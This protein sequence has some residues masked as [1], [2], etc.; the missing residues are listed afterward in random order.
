GGRARCGARALLSLM[1]SDRCV[2]GIGKWKGPF[3]RSRK[4]P[5]GLSRVSLLPL[6]S[7]GAL[8]RLHRGSGSR[9]TN[10][11]QSDKDEDKKEA[12]EE[13]AVAR[14]VRGL[15]VAVCSVERNGICTSQRHNPLRGWAG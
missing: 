2:I 13:R 1:A 6:G 12:K 5:L 10:K 9:H 3:R 8:I 11:S 15:R 14:H 4:G 7:G